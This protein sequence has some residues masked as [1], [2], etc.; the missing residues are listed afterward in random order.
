M[1]S[2]VFKLSIVQSCP[3]EF[4]NFSNGI[5]LLYASSHSHF[6]GSMKCGGRTVLLSVYDKYFS[7]HFLKKKLFL[8]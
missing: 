6:P 5:A 2:Q 8:Q 1:R 7:L 4:D 3:S